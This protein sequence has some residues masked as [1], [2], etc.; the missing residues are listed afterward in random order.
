MLYDALFPYI[1][2]LNLFSAEPVKALHFAILVWATIINFWHSGVLVLKTECQSAR[3]SKIKN[4]GLDQCGT[5][6]FKQQQF[7]TAGVERDKV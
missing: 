1:I 5:E 6:P 3:M 4:R 7:G 2:C